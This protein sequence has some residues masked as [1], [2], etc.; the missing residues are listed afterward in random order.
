MLLRQRRSVCERLTFLK[1]LPTPSLF[2][3]YYYFGVHCHTAM[4]LEPVV[5]SC[6]T[7]CSFQS[8]EPL[9]TSII[10][11]QLFSEQEGKHCSAR[12]L[13]A[14]LLRRIQK[15]V[16]ALIMLWLD[17]QIVALRGSAH[18]LGHDLFFAKQRLKKAKKEKGNQHSPKKIE[19]MECACVHMLVSGAMLPLEEYHATNE[20]VVRQSNFSL[21]TQ[22]PNQ[23]PSVKPV[24]PPP[25]LSIH[26]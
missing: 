24:E 23:T 21:E 1:S 9:S 16:I 8:A 13:H 5:V 3:Y 25:P 20:N 22:T 12:G 18:A 6:G 7:L 14:E 4:D 11:K 19:G 26:S 17:L 10:L 15:K 2:T